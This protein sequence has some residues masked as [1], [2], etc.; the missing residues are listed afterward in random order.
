MHKDSAV[1]L[2]S[3]CTQIAIIGCGG[4]GWC[5]GTDKGDRKSPHGVT[6][7]FSTLTLIAAVS[8][9]LWLLNVLVYSAQCVGDF[10]F[11]TETMLENDWHEV[12]FRQAAVPKIVV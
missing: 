11:E 2:L 7:S 3:H 9:A 5:D 10:F 8:V 1:I 12:D 4:R 6:R